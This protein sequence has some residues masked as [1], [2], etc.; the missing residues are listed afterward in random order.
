MERLLDQLI[1]RVAVEVEKLD[2][3]SRETLL[4]LNEGILGGDSGA[5]RLRKLKKGSYRPHHWILIG[6]ERITEPKR[7]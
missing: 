2:H 3:H 1:T 6:Q 7:V 4:H 5:V